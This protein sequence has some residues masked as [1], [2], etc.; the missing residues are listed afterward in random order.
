MVGSSNW[1]GAQSISW[2]LGAYIVGKR[3][4]KKIV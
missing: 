2:L 1:N 4:M 3:I